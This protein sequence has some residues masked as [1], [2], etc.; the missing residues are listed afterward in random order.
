MLKPWSGAP[1]G[2]ACQRFDRTQIVDSAAL[3]L[4]LALLRANTCDGA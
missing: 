2:T 1:R 4:L 3:E